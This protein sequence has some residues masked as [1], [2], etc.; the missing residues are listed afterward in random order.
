MRAQSIGGV[1]TATMSM[2]AVLILV[3]GNLFAGSVATLGLSIRIGVAYDGDM[4]GCNTSVM[5]GPASR[6]T[7]RR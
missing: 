4:S 7:P 6:V 3:N 1:A 2:S 5:D